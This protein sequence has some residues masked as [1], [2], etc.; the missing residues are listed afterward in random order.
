MFGRLTNHLAARHGYPGTKPASRRTPAGD[1]YDLRRR[2]DGYD[3]FFG[4][5]RVGYLEGRRVSLTIAADHYCRQH[6]VGIRA[7]KAEEV[8]SADPNHRLFRL[9]HTAV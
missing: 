4:T 3:V 2:G 7:V 6:G 8:K 5:E 9:S 1:V